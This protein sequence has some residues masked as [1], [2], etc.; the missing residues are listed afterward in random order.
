MSGRAHDD[1]IQVNVDRCRGSLEAARHLLALKHYDDTASRAY[2]AAFY[3]A[4]AILASKGLK[5][6]KHRGLIAAVHRDLVRQGTIS[7]DAGRGLSRLFELRG[8]GDYGSVER[9]SPEAAKEALELAE[10]FV[11]KAL[12]TLPPPSS[13]GK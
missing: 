7:A 3:A 11:E 5:F 10:M 13:E 6:S 9:V 1:E 8:I 2:Y 4:T 12:R